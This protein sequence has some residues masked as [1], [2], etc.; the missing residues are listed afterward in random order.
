MSTSTLIDTPA[1]IAVE[2]THDTLTVT[3]ADGRVISVPVLWYPRLAHGTA[4]DREHWELIG[5]GHGIHW[6]ELDEDISVEGIL[7]GRPSGE[8]AR[9]LARWREWYQ[10][11]KDRTSGSR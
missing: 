11:K 1:A 6:P 4:K 10:T 9:S 2:V 3:L 5:A 7:H 8:G